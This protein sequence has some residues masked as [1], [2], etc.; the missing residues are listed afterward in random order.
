MSQLEEDKIYRVER[1]R[2]RESRI[3]QAGVDIGGGEG[4]GLSGELGTVP[5]T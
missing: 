2:E 1:E 3:R 5:E 4:G